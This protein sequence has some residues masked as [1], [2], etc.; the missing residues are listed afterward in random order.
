MLLN[1]LFI[2]TPD[3]TL[4]KVLVWAD[5]WRKGKDLATG[6]A[7]TNFMAKQEEQ[8]QHLRTE[9]FRLQEV[10]GEGGDSHVPRRL[11]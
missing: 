9:P 3:P 1:G 6:I 2:F 5:D 4:W 8:A 10:R 11:D 7:H